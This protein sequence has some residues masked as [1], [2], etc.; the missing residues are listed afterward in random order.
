MARG[1]VCVI[2]MAHVAICVIHMA[3]GSLKKSL[4]D[5]ECIANARVSR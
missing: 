1:A 3:H 5:D 4:K 2:R